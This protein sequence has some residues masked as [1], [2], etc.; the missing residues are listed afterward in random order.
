MALLPILSGGGAKS[1]K[2]AG[3]FR[4]E[5]SGIVH[6]PVGK[7]S[8]STVDLKRNIESFIDSL[9]RAKPAASKG[10]YLRRLSL[11]TSMGLSLRVD[12]SSYR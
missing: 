6:A 1:N 3:S 2:R 11:S 5:K 9:K 7:T 8:F 4:A 10:L 12:M